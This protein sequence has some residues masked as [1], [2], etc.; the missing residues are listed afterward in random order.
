MAGLLLKVALV[1]LIGAAILRVHLRG[2]VRHSWRHQVFDHSSVAAPVNVLMYACSSVPDTPFVC[3]SA[4]PDLKILQSHWLEIRE[5][6]Q[7]LLDAQHIRAA[8]H[9]DDAGFNS[10]FKYGWKRFYL[11]W[12]GEAHP[13]AE[14][15][16][17][18]TTA[19]LRTLPSVKA[20]MFAWLPDGGKLNP[21][22]DPY[23]GS[24]RYHLGLITPNDDRCYI[25][26]DGQRYSWRD[27]EGVVFDE[28]FIHRAENHSGQGRL[29]L[30]CD[31][32]RPM[33]YS[34]A[35]TLNNWVGQNIVAAASSPNRDGD[36]CGALS[37]LFRYAGWVGEHRKRFKR[38][39]PRV[40]RLTRVGLIGSVI[41][42]FLLI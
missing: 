12:Y 38:W 22:R 10:F 30:F 39:N 1:L 3:V 7:R 32:E 16:C 18:R 24:L 42:L 11:K 8:Q 41:A 20:A 14:V 4:F 9:N 19:L 36:H 2:R 13:S 34:W 40:Y 31:I 26:V 23:A 37:R 6:G 15:L 29:I 17:P 5:E 35:S 27:G 33:R 21:H 28:T 25:E